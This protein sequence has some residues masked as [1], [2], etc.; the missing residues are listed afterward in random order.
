ML[1]FNCPSPHCSGAAEIFHFRLIRI[2][3]NAENS[4]PSTKEEVS[5]ETRR[6]AK[7]LAT[8]NYPANFIRNGRKPKRQQAWLGYPKDFPR[9][10]QKFFE[11][12]T[13]R[14]LISLSAP[15]PAYLQSQKTRSRKRLPKESWTRSKVKIVIA[16]SFGQTP[17]AQK[18]PTSKNT[19][20]P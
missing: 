3:S 1:H 13:S 19:Q 17:R 18:K 4:I 7:A 6:I 16:F 12:S 8:Y 14:S 2:H 10:S 9:E 11:V 5:R 20:R 15:S